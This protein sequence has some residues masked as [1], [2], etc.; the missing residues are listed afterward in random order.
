MEW[1]FPSNNE[2]GEYYLGKTS[3]ILKIDRA[4]ISVSSSF[5]ALQPTINFF[6][7][8][9]KIM[10]GNQEDKINIR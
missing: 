3:I 8:R 9:A 6:T 2:K 4:L 10:I 7:S 5:N 1:I